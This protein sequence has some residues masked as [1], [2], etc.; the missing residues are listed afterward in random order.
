MRTVHAILVFFF[1][2]R[3]RVLARTNY[4]NPKTAGRR[5]YASLVATVISRFLRY[6][7]RKNTKKT[8]Q[9]NELAVENYS[10]TPQY[11][12]FPLNRFRTALNIDALS[13]ITFIERSQNQ[14]FALGQ[15]VHNV[16]RSRKWIYIFPWLFLPLPFC[17]FSSLPLEE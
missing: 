9:R 14:S 17:L 13:N 12:L 10:A 2:H 11:V 15:T 16:A 5:F 1:S 4:S 7:P 6:H 3:G 8:D